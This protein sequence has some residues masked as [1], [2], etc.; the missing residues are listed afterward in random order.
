MS[1]VS[2]GE[3]MSLFLAIAI[4]LGIVI[5]WIL[6][7]E[8]NRKF[9]KNEIKKLKAHVDNVERE[10]F[11]ITEEASILKDAAFTGEAAGEDSSSGGA[12]EAG[13]DKLI[14]K[15]IMEKNENFEKEN[16]KLK[17]ELDE[18]RSSLEEIYEAMCK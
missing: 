8:T 9:L 4:A 17:E 1:G 13:P 7:S 5:A 10:K 6:K 16:I 12:K 2:V 3:I 15:K 11:M 18:A 14:I